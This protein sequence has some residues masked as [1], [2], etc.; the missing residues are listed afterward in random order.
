MLLD[1]TA[2]A[3]TYG[4]EGA[5]N[6]PAAAIMAAS[7]TLTAGLGARFSAKLN[8]PRLQQ[9]PALVSTL[10]VVGCARACLQVSLG[11]GCNTSR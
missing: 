8:G 5:V 7:A 2:G 6:L 11:G 10:C 3:T 9:V 1:S 4:M